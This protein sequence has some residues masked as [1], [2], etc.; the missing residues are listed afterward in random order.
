MCQSV[1]SAD[2]G[3]DTPSSGSK[4]GY[5]LEDPVTG[6][7]ANRVGRYPPKPTRW[8]QAAALHDPAHDRDDCEYGGNEHELADL[9]VHCP[10]ASFVDLKLVAYILVDVVQK[11]LV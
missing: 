2:I 5:A 3:R 9:D 10:I 1:E 7:A 6:H 11:S 8:R 4:R